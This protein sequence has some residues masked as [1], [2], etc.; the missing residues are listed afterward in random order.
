MTEEF[1]IEK[2]PRKPM[3][4]EMR[5]ES[6]VERA[7]RRAAEIKQHGAF[8]IE[9]NIDKFYINPDDV[10]EGW[11]YEWKRLTL[12]GKEDPSY[13]VNLARTGWEAVPAERHPSYMP[14][15]NFRHIERDGM[16]LMERPKVLTDEARNVE[17]RRARNQV[18]AK[19]EQ[20]SST[21]SGT[22]TREH[23]NV[24]P[25]VKKSYSPIPVP[26]DE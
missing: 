21:P 2:A 26:G 25:T 22:M 1:K 16:I 24:R 6:P 10:P 4:S 7:K 18:R 12:L 19:E 20:L 8:S 5:D 14:E 23:Q 11:S 17:S 15:G 9:D 3:R 13:Q